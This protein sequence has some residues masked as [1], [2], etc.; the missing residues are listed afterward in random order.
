MPKVSIIVPIYNGAIDLSR[1]VE[2]ILRSRHKDIEVLLVNDG[3]TDSTPELCRMFAQRDA[4]VVVIDQENSGVSRAR[5]AAIARATGDYLQFVDADDYVDEN[6]TRLLVERMEETGADMVISRYCRVTGKQTYV[7][8]YLNTPHPLSQREY[9]LRLMERPASF[10][11][12]VMWNKLY[13]R[14]LVMDHDIRCD[15]SLGFCEDTLFNFA[16]YRQMK[17]VAVLQTPIYYYVRNADG[18]TAGALSLRSVAESKAK[19]FPYYKALCEQLGLYED[20]KLV[21][22]KYLISSALD[23]Y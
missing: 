23:E 17:T 14:D 12:G 5:N 16:Y 11:Y 7:H 15:E 21:I 19:L 2:S 18:L 22:H 3:S 6:A 20:N 9:I 8:G 13:R 10:Y 1:C 4:R